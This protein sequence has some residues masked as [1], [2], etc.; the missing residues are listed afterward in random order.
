MGGAVAGTPATKIPRS[1]PEAEGWSR[2][3]MGLAWLTTG[4]GSWRTRIP[5]TSEQ[6]TGT[7]QT[8]VREPLGLRIEPAGKSSAAE[9]LKCRRNQ[10]LM[11][12]PGDPRPYA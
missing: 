5:W 1:R 4:P 11:A 7:G 10:Q 9:R 2:C 12:L 3:A 8:K 6:T